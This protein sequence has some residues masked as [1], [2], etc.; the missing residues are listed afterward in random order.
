MFAYTSALLERAKAEL[1]HLSG[2]R[3]GIT[4]LEYGILAAIMVAALSA[5]FGGV[6]GKL[7]DLF[8]AVGG[9]LSL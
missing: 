3:K 5:G 4:A 8:N 7:S 9:K 1:S 6:T 2:D